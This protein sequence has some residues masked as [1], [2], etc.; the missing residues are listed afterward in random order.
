MVLRLTNIIDNIYRV[1]RLQP[2]HWS[3]VVVVV[4]S[5]SHKECLTNHLGSDNEDM[6]YQVFCVG[7]CV[8]QEGSMIANGL[9]SLEDVRLW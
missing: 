2:F 1:C 9:R 8:T 7:T 3:P 4:K 5:M 6:Y